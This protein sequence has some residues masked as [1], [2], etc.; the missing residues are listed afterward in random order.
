VFPACLLV[1]EI[2][3]AG[4][5]WLA[6]KFSDL[7]RGRGDVVPCDTWLPGAMCGISSAVYISGAVELFLELIER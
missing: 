4:L 1:H 5:I 6:V 7:E 3:E 2:A